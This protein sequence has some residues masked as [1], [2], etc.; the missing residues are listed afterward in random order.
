MDKEQLPHL[1]TFARAAELNSFTAAARDLRVTQ[2]AVSQRIQTLEQSLGVPLFDRQGGHVLLTDAGRRLYDYARRILDLHRDAVREI[3]GRLAPLTGELTLA[4]SSVPGEHLLPDLLATFRQRQPHIQVRVS[5]SDTQDVVHQ[6]EQGR[7]QLGLVGG[8][9]DSTHMEFRSFAEDT[10][11][12]V[13]PR[14][15]AWARRKRVPLAQFADEPLILREAGSASR[16]CLE[17]ALS[18]TDT[19]LSAMRVSLELGSN[20]AIKEAVRRG[21]GLAVLST[22]VVRREVEAGQLHAVEVSGLHLTRDMYVVC[23]RRRA[24]PIPARLFV[25][26]LTLG[27]DNQP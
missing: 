9:I 25:D 13:V 7:A 20:E 21:L 8:K 6:V 18:A 17:Q 15:H 3:T 27:R 16:G 24:M 5:V 23:D 22:H 14:S 26:L 12:V 4:A 2:A 1:N 11:V 19:P 10:L